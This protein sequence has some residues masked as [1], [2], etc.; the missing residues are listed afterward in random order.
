MKGRILS[1]EKVN[2]IFLLRTIQIA[3]EITKIMLRAGR[4]RNLMRQGLRI[5]YLLQNVRT[6]SGID[7]TLYAMS[8]R[9]PSPGCKTAVA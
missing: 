6:D 9:G 2:R 1:Y 8:T 4:S 3:A 7:L 5:I